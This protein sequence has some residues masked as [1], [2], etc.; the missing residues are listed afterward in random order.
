MKHKIII[1]KTKIR[2]IVLK[3][4]G[5]CAN[6]KQLHQFLL[7]SFCLAQTIMILSQGVAFAEDNS[8]ENAFISMF[9]G[10]YTLVLKISTAAGAVTIAVA[11]FM[12][13]FSSDNHTVEM[14][15]GWIKRIIKA[16]LIINCTGAIMSFLSS[17]ITGFT[18]SSGTT[19]GQS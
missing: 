4:K 2:G 18:W 13:Y 5:I 14:A 1:G 11:G 15:N 3:I 8:L 16:W 19:N 12:M 7:F 10:V 6:E 9:D 17:N